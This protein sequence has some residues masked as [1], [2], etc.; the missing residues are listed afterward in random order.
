MGLIMSL[1]Y[2]CLMTL[3]LT[4]LIYF[5]SVTISP[6]FP[7]SLSLPP[8]PPASSFLCLSLLSLSFPL[9]YTL[10]FISVVNRA[11][12]K[13]YIQKRE[14]FGDGRTDE[15]ISVSLEPLTTYRY[16][17]RGLEVGPYDRMWKGPVLGGVCCLS[18]WLRV[19]ERNRQVVPGGSFPMV[20]SP[21]S[22]PHPHCGITWAYIFLFRCL[23]FCRCLLNMKLIFFSSVVNI[24][25]CSVISALSDP[26]KDRRSS[27]SWIW[28]GFSILSTALSSR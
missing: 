13:D 18:Q 9:D 12:M 1:L 8:S 6:T 17:S 10:I 27:N 22:L 4:P 19:Q 20:P 26:H 16:S 15:N 2:L 25:F 24:L 21:P 3:I 14:D 11:W 28:F 23:K 5:L 7:S